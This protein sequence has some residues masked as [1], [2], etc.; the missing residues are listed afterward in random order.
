[1][2]TVVVEVELSTARQSTE[3]RRDAATEPI[4]VERKLD[5]CVELA[6]PW[7]NDPKL[8]YC[9]LSTR[10]IKPFVLGAAHFC[11]WHGTF[12]FL[13]WA[14]FCFWCGHIFV[15]GAAH[16]ATPTAMT[17]APTSLCADL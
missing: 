11:F 8:C 14:H 1:M 13:V 3:R 5:E 2:N 15:F 4:V 16:F 7:Y 6:I 12:L 9:P 10:E 17:F